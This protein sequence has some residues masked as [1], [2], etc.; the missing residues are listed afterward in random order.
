MKRTLLPLLL[1]ANT[2]LAAEGIEGFSATFDPITLEIG[3][4]D[5][6]QIIC[7]SPTYPKGED[8]VPLEGEVFLSLVIGENGK[9]DEITVSQSS[10]DT[11][12]DE[13][14]LKNASFSVFGEHTNQ[15]IER[16]F[17]FELEN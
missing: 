14:A 7:I 1:L 16:K 15:T 17:T 6:S 10:G 3:R 2:A 4:A 13:A 5:E 9:A 11:R 12:I 8:G